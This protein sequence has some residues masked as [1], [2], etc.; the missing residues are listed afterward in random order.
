MP[1][2]AKYH[3]L[4]LSVYTQA[5]KWRASAKDPLGRETL[6]ENEFATAETAKGAALGNAD[7]HLKHHYPEIDYVQLPAERIRW[8][9]VNN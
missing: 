1:F 6:L 3:H 9:E 8:E 7:L 2:K 5:G 4:D